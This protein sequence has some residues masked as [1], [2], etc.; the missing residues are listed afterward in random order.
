[1]ASLW[2]HPRS[3]F[4]SACFTARDGRRLKRSTK[5]TVRRDAQRIADAFEEAARTRRT[6]RQVREVIGQLHEA[7]TGEE[8]PDT[9]LRDFA[10]NWL[11]RKAPETA[12]S[13]LGF[14]TGSVKKFLDHLGTDAD[15]RLEEI[16][17]EQITGYRN[18]LAA[19]L[20]AKTTN[21]DLKVVRM[22]F[23]AARRDGLV[24]EDPA[25]FVEGV[26]D[27][28]AESSRRP[29][30]L[31]ELRAVLDVAD[32]EW[33]S[34]VLFGLYSGQRLGDLARL[35]WANV[36]IV[37]GELRLKT[38]KTGRRV[39]LPL[40]E[41]L[42]RHL[43]A[44]PSADDPTAPLHARAFTTIQRTGKAGGLSN[45]FTVLLVAAGLREGRT[46]ASR[47][48]GRG[49]AR[50]KEGLSFHSLRHTATSL[51]HDAGLPAAVVQEFI[52]HDSAEVHEGYVTVGREALERAAAALPDLVGKHAE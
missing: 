36:D 3:K 34:L 29:F 35:T 39:R 23:R 15:K 50:E 24:A 8:L 44:V 6:A 41:P 4:W 31:P 14:Y 16:T 32:D 52:G 33:R 11:A 26:K 27:H 46:H 43:F 12:A 22:L 49:A 40:A 13:T 30:T 20:T 42:R 37:R 19:R 7:L 18:S 10:K 1:M 28:G 9:S 5:T 51:L 38:G 17:R 48:K 21:H 45:A 2:K 25:E 47:G